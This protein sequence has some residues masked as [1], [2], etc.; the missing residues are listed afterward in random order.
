MLFLWSKLNLL[1]H[2]CHLYVFPCYL[3]IS[4]PVL[5]FL[6]LIRALYILGYLCY[7]TNV[8]P[9]YGLPFNGIFWQKIYIS[10]IQI[11]L[12]PLQFFLLYLCLGSALRT[13]LS[14]YVSLA[15]IY[16]FIM[17]EIYYIWN[18]HLSCLFITLSCSFYI[19]HMLF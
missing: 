6:F 19:Y 5:F 8:F 7:I 9:T 10:N 13:I 15:Y 18:L 16:I 3:F 11:Y 17:S 2:F 14:L 12:S 1:S 4:T